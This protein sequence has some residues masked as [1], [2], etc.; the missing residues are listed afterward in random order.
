MKRW[1]IIPK[2]GGGEEEESMVE[3]FR[4][5]L[6]FCA[7]AAGACGAGVADPRTN[8]EIY[9]YQGADRE[10]R[11]VERAKQE[12][13][14]VLYST[15]TVQD[16]RVLAAAFE[17]KYGVKVTHWRGSAEKIVQRT[18]AESRAGRN[19]VDVIETSAH[20]MEALYREKLL[21][22]STRR[23]STSFRPPPSRAS[24]V[25]TWPTASPSS[26][27]ATTPIWSSRRRFRRATKTCCIQNGPGGWRSNRP[28]SSGS[29]RLPRR[30]GRTRASPTFGG[31]RR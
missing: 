29:P 9:L 24:T 23:H 16:G 25:S 26:S 8:R 30:W 21:E 1:A 15:M 18:L 3:V 6:L 20:R 14:V 12:G 13:P 19:E 27:W 17:R 31:W 10:A 4:R 22:D 28:T 11:L 7:L 2:A 5:R